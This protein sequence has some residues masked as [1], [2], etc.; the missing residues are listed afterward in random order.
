M[1]QVFIIISLLLLLSAISVY[2]GN[3]CLSQ[4]QSSTDTYTDDVERLRREIRE[5]TN[6]INAQRQKKSKTLKDIQSLDKEIALRDQ[7]LHKLNQKEWRLSRSIRSTHRE[8][9][10]NTEDLANLQNSY[11]KRAVHLYKYGRTFELEALFLSESFSRALVRLKY[12]RI[13]MEQERKNILQIRKLLSS[14]QNKNTGLKQNLSEQKELISSITKEKDALDSRR[15]SRKTDLTKINKDETFLMG[16]IEEK[17]QSIRR[18]LDLVRQVNAQHLPSGRRLRNQ[19]D[20]F[21]NGVSFASL[22]GR[23]PWPVRGQVSSHFG[24]NRNPK[25]KTQIDNPGIDIKAAFGTDVRAV[26][27]GR[28]AMVTWLPGFGNMVFIEHTNQFCSIYGH[29]SEVSVE[30]GMTVK[31]G[32]II[33]KVGDSGSYEGAKLN[34]Q[35]WRNDQKVDPEEWLQ[36]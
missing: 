24:I 21:I 9:S 10:K 29:L 18:I 7:L 17:N 30:V 31:A 28:V 11:S 13:I 2:Y 8:I 32:S 22:R 33:G 25:L 35:I 23:L 27:D 3:H 36:G 1:R 15:S 5:L 16:Q 19:E 4:Q 12:L 6:K 20:H 14:L 26:G 34:F